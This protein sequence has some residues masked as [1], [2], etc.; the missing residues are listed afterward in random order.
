MLA[1]ERWQQILGMLGSQNVVSVLELSRRLNS[2]EVTIRR[3]LRELELAGKLKRT[4][5]GAISIQQGNTSFEPHFAK[6]ASENIALKQ[7]I[8]FKAREM[9]E[10][11][12]AIMID[13]ASTCL[14][15]CKSIQTLPLTNLMVVTNSLR[16]VTELAGCDF[17]ELVH[18]GGQVRKNTLSSTG[19]LASLVLGQIKVD[20]VFLGING[21][22][23]NDHV[24]TTPNLSESAVKRAMIGCA[25]ETIILADHTK[26]NR[27]YLSL[28]CRTE[29][30]DKIVTDRQ[31]PDV[32]REQADAAGVE[33][34]VAD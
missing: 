32:I 18:I 25:H 19:H 7:S 23:L 27:N 8:G 5:G 10:N 15:L 1:E 2:S 6:L 11:N 21:I 16:V 3:D 22:D 33:L 13:S 24:L 26:F 34:V 20:K 30:V 9:I 29:D 14:W 28:V 12:S 17:V 4:H 31:V